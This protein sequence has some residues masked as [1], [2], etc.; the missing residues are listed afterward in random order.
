MTHVSRRRRSTLL[1]AGAAALALVAGSTVGWAATNG[2]GHGA[3]TESTPE[4]VFGAYLAAGHAEE[5]HDYGRAADLLDRILEER[6]D[7]PLLQRRAMLANLHAGR[8]AR[9]V[10]LARP[11]V[12]VYPGEVDIAAL[13]LAA[14]AILSGDWPRAIKALSPPRRV[15]LARFATPVLAAWAHQAR[16]DTADAM[17]ALS[18]LR[19]SADVPALHDYHAGLI[20]LNAGRPE[21]AEAI[22]SPY[23]DDLEGSGIGLIR[24]LARARLALDDRE[25]AEAL[26]R[27]FNAMNPGFTA[28]ERDIA[29][30]ER[31]GALP[32]LVATAAEGA[33]D[34]MI[35]L[36]RQVRGRA[37]TIALRYT[38]LGVYMDPTNDLGRML[39]AAILETHD[40]HAE[41]IAELEAVS[42]GSEF[43]WDARI[44][45]GDN[46]ILLERD[47]E[48]I[49]HLEAMSEE[50]DDDL[51]ALE[52]LGYLMR[53]RERYGE[54]TEYYDR[55]LARVDTVEDIHWTLF[56]HR[57][58]TLE[59]T[60]RWPEAE[61]DFKRALELKPDDPYVLNYLGYS[62]V[63]QGMNIEEAMEMIRTA[64]EQRPNDG[65][66]VDSLGWA[67]YRLDDFE[68]AVVHLERAVQ[69]RPQDPVINDH[70]GDAYYR[71][72]R[73]LE[74]RFQWNRALGLDPEE[75]EREKIERKLLRGLDAVEN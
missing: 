72:G 56:Y 17:D 45:I 31:D 50:R 25:G 20:F 26:L 14:D 71:V 19:D 23:G 63:D 43:D 3:D 28:L 49:A 7:D 42:E 46:L 57:G 65:Y 22:L 67:Y 70:L 6:G 48:A 55:A 18:V 12:A 24:A 10:D 58:I 41:A 74:A 40:R 47:D 11:Q 54:G 66:I 30:L 32:P 1:I 60:K 75:D 36:S 27:G 69:L 53:L 4:T 59:R 29:A 5:G 38:R 16:G 52:R 21:E 35:N 15:A 64:V 13:T 51:D 68:E 44:E 61:A 2:S 37:P 33:A 62:W 8:L 9:A 73:D 39:I 34:A